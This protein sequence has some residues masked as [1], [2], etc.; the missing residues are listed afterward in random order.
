MDDRRG[1]FLLGSILAGAA[2]S[3]ESLIA[4][5][6]LQGLGGG[7]LIPVGTTL[8]ARSAGPRR[9]GRVMTVPGFPCCSALSSVLSSAAC[10]W[11]TP[12][13]AGLLRERADRRVARRFHGGTVRAARPSPAATA[14]RPHR[15]PASVAGARPLVY[16]LAETSTSGQHQQQTLGLI[17]LGLSLVTVF[18]LHARRAKRPLTC[19]SSGTVPSGMARAPSFFLGM[20][21]FGVMFLLPLYYQ[22]ARGLTPLDAGL[23]M[24]PQGIGAVMMMIFSGRATDRLGSGRVVWGGSRCWCSA[25]CPSRSRTPRPPPLLTLGLVVRGMGLGATR[26]CRRWPARSASRRRARGRRRER[27]EHGQAHGWRAG[28]CLAVSCAGASPP[29]EHGGRWDSRRAGLGR[30]RRIWGHL[31][32][33]G[34]LLRA[35]V[36]SRPLS[37]SGAGQGLTADSSTARAEVSA[38]D[39][40]RQESHVRPE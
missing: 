8:L 7:L 23:M 30:G 14:V 5:R 11:S 20:G 39:S 22:G 12:D 16:G 1:A 34:R 28:S 37:P 26:R 29:R 18:V 33:D 10:S 6:F 19:G 21:L 25:R 31:L 17:A 15:F 27:V 24:A 3:I 32:V 36:R 35:G 38:R 13:G 2:W 4:F 40:T 9:V